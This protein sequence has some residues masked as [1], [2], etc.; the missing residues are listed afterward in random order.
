MPP[1]PKQRWIYRWCMMDSSY[2]LA[3]YLTADGRTVERQFFVPSMQDVQ[4]EVA[5]QNGVLQS[6][7]EHR[8]SWLNRE[9]Y[10]QEYKLD[11]LKGLAFN[12]DAGA[13]AAQSLLSL[14]ESE[15]HPR[16]R[17]ELQP[18]LEV[19]GRGGQFSDALAILP[20]IDATLVVL[21]QT[22]DASGAINE[23]IADSVAIMEQRGAAWKMIGAAI[24]WMG[25]DLFSIVSTVLGIQ[26]FALPW[27][28]SNPPVL[29]DP[30]KV[31]EY[32]RQLDLVAGA[33][34]SMTLLTVLATMLVMAFGI[35]FM[36]GN[37]AVKDWLHRWVVRVPML[38]SIFV[39][40]ALSDGLLLL[41]RMEKNGVPMPH[42][43]DLLT[44]FSRIHAV[45]TFWSAVRQALD[46]GWGVTQAFAEGKLFTGQELNALGSHQNREQASKIMAL[47]A[48]RR[49]Q[50]AETGTKRF[51]RL[52]VI[53]TVIYM[54]LSMGLALWLLSLQNLGLSGSFEELMKGGF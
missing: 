4:R 15:S 16:K 22:A 36:W 54:V 32:T 44:T 24:G 50:Q 33:S 1:R 9:Y 7:T 14:I 3:R 5:Q 49:R 48:Q 42:A 35:A 19:L 2:F 53:V 51:I 13:S 43:L 31:A 27:F 28:R 20:F 40:G 17:A 52:S 41:S 10:S 39:D 6:I 30:I 23:A 18:A 21:L 29:Q 46:A 26:F 8:R 37:T 45:R 47:L 34:L 12:I 38:R 11:F 25:F